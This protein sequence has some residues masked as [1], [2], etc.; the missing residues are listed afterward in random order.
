ME[1]LGQGEN[2]AAAGFQLLMGWGVG[3]CRSQHLESVQLQGGQGGLPSTLGHKQILLS[4]A[5]TTA[6]KWTA[7]ESPQHRLQGSAESHHDDTLRYTKQWVEETQ[8]RE[9]KKEVVFDTT[10]NWAEPY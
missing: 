10:M 7:K 9:E 8:D 1:T 4:L 3:R 6:Q 2:T 5:L